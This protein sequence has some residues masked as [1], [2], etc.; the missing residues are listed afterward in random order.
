MIRLTV[1]PERAEELFKTVKHAK[2]QLSKAEHWQVSDDG[3]VA[4]LLKV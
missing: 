1:S 3:S 4:V 2:F